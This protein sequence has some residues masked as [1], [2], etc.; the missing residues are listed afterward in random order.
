MCS[1][2]SGFRRLPR[3]PITETFVEG[4]RHPL[5]VPHLQGGVHGG[6]IQ[7]RPRQNDQER[8]HQVDQGARPESSDLH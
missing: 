8:A 5:H 4:V 6:R 7:P 3:R 1:F 2:G